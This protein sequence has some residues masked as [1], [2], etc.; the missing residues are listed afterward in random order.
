M[1]MR[2]LQQALLGRPG[3]PVVGWSGREEERVRADP[4]RIRVGVG[5]VG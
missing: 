4:G 5:A 3:R 2:V 1:S